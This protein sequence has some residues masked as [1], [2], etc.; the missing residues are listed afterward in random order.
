MLRRRRTSPAEPISIVREDYS[1]RKQTV[2]V[3]F[4]VLPSSIQSRLPPILSRPTTPTISGSG[5]KPWNSPG[6]SGTITPFTEADTVVGDEYGIIPFDPDTGALDHTNPRAGVDWRCGRP[7]LELL[8]SAIDESKNAAAAMRSGQVFSHNPTF[9]RRAYLDGVSY[10]LRGLPQDMDETEM[11]IL[12]RALPSSIAEVGAEPRGQL[13]F[14]GQPRDE[15]Q[16]PSMLH[17]SLRLVVARAIVWFCILWPYI[18]VLLRWAAAYERKHRISEQVVGQAMA[19]GTT[20]GNW[21]MSVSEAI[22]SRGDGKVGRALAD[23]VAW[24]VHDMVAGVSEGVQD[25]LSRSGQKLGP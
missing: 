10:L 19:M 25:G 4:S 17:K 14:F 2:S 24:A 8:I 3:I 16:K 22:C 18:L 11:S 15:Y 5:D 9:E 7:G 23:I 1:I 12:R 21:A 13:G 6:S 20:C